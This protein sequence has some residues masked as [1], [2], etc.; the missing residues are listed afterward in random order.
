MDITELRQVQAALSQSQKMEAIGTLAGGIAHDFNN[1]LTVI[2]GFSE[3]LLMGK[4]EGDSDQ[5]DLRKILQAAG[6]GADLVKQ[7]LAFGRKIEIRV[8]PLDLNHAVQQ[9]LQMLSR[10]IPKMITIDTYLAD[11]LKRINAD[12]GQM[13]QVLLNLAINA[14]DAMPDGGKLVIETENVVLDSLGCNTFLKAG[15]ESMSC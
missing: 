13:Q 9:T 3:L 2:H 5:A 14:R 1:I 11:D 8:R 6:K 4:I 7:I 10:T 15:P 12:P